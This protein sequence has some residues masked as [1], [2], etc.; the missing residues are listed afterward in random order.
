AGRSP[1]AGALGL[2]AAARPGVRVLRLGPAAPAVPVLLDACLAGP[3]AE[4][5]QLGTFPQAALEL[6]EAGE[7]GEANDVVPQCSGFGFVRKSADDR[8]EEGHPCRRLEVD[9][10]RTDVFTGERQGF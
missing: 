4:A 5:G 7:S 8:P 6:G 10:R 2:G 9:D 3:Y 1:A